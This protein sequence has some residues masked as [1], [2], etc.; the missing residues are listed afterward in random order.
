MLRMA[1]Q[2]QRGRQLPSNAS[3]VIP[4]SAFPLED[5]AIFR[6]TIDKMYTFLMAPPMHDPNQ[7]TEIFWSCLNQETAVELA[8]NKVKLILRNN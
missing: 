5:K 7:E 2:A 3:M 6:E 1:V 8:V 4:L